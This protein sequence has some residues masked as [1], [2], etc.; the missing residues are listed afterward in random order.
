M[1]AVVEQFSVDKKFFDIEKKEFS[2]DNDRLLNH[3][4]CQDVMNIAM[5]T[6][7]VPV[8]V[9]SANNKFFV[10]DN[11]EIERLEQENDHLFELLLSQDIVHICVNSLASRN[12]CREMQQ[13]FIDEYNKNLMLKAE[14]AK[15]EHMVEMKT[16]DE[17][18]LR[19]SR[20]ESRRNNVVEKDVQRNNPNVIA[21]E[22]F[23]LDLEPL[24]P[25]LLNNRDAHTDYIKHSWEHADTLLEIVEHAR[26]LR[27]LDSDL[28][29]AAVATAYFTQNRSLIRKRHNKTPYELIYNKKPDLSY[30]YVFGAL[31][32][33][34]NDSEDLG[35]LKTNIDIRIFVG[36][37]PAKKAL[38][39][40]NKRARPIIKTIHFN[41]DELTA[42]ASEQFS[43]GPEPQLLTPRTLILAVV[44]PEPADSVGSPSSTPV[45]QDAPS[46]STSQTPQESQSPVTSPWRCRRVS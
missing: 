36:Y 16:F 22:M 38:L 10:N 8:N 7:Y 35:K 5:H 1:E 3:I 44:A 9:Q 32:Y 29:S 46:P 12:D 45:D 21:P 31:C 13:G 41:F 30:L 11:L 42:M 2:L 39:I 14:L 18:V 26:A 6:D 24:A 20:L 19:C 33:P 15:K 17:V 28:D 43:S 40:Y 4:I 23:K 37:A 27:P 25:K 34:T